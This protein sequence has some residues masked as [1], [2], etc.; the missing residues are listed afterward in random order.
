MP[1]MV[2]PGVDSIIIILPNLSIAIA[3]RNETEKKR[4]TNLKENIQ[5]TSQPEQ[6]V[7]LQPKKFKSKKKKKKN[8]T[9]SSPI[10]FSFQSIG[11]KNDDD[12][13]GKSIRES[14]TPLSTIFKH[15][16]P[17]EDSRLRM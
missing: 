2:S 15:L 8:V 6:N 1:G 13:H 7:T 3:Y 4:N 17:S 11:K 5:T 14:T 16:K 12:D 10:F 9:R